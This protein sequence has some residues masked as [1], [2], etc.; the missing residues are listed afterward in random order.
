MLMPLL[1]VVLGRRGLIFAE[2]LHLSRWY[3]MDWSLAVT[4]FTLILFAEL[5]DKTQLTAMSLAASTGRPLPVAAGAI[6]GLA[7][8][9]ILAVSV[10]QVLPRIMPTLWIRRGA[11]TLFVMTGLLMLIGAF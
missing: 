11:G 3:R 9:T 7:V 1:H 8:S 10:G 6:S 5:G 4:T 2:E